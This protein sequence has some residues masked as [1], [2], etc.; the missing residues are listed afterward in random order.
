[1][2]VMVVPMLAPMTI[3]IAFSTLSS[4]A[5]TAVTISEV[6]VEEL[7]TSTVARMPSMTPLKGFSATSNILAESFPPTSLNP[8]LSTFKLRKNVHI[9]AGTDAPTNF[10]R[11]LT[12][13]K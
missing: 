10:L 7:W 8:V 6:L 13:D 11:Q 2:L 4:P 1:M 5:A 9:K 3:A 12:P